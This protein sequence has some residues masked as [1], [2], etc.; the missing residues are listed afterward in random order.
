MGSDSQDPQQY[1][2]RPS[3]RED[4]EVI[5]IPRGAAP[6]TQTRVEIPGTCCNIDEQPPLIT[7]TP[8]RR[9]RVADKLD[10]LR[11]RHAATIADGAANHLIRA[12]A[13]PCEIVMDSSP[14]QWSA[15]MLCCTIWL[16]AVHSAA[17]Y[18]VKVCPHLHQRSSSAMEKQI[19]LMTTLQKPFNQDCSCTKASTCS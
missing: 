5:P 12:T 14:L 13:R 11:Q 7:H 19:R 1:S 18:C 3:S 4:S 2:P 17:D 9:A 16:Q 15:R 10:L 6:C 8:K